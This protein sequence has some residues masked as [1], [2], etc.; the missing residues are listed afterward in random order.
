VARPVLGKYTQ[1]E[2]YRLVEQIGM[3]GMS[4]VWRA[5]D[6]VLD[7]EV[8]VKLLA[9]GAS[10]AVRERLRIEARAVAKLSHPYIAPVF[11]YGEFTAD[12]GEVTPFV[13]MELI[14][15]PSLS[16]QLRDEATPPWRDTVR[17]GAQVAAALAFAHAHGIVHR[18]VT[19]A[20]VLITSGGAKVV[21]FGIAAAVGDLELDADGMV[22]GTP[23]YL[24]PERLTGGTVGTAGDIYGL[25]LLIY[26]CLRGRLPWSASTATAMVRAHQYAEPEPLPPLAGVPAEVIDLCHACIAREPA[27][28]PSAI[29]VAYV[30]ADIV[31]LALPLA[32]PRS[33]PAWGHP[34]G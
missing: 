25:G 27:A 23:A 28:R 10:P 29:E 11:D 1:V 6:E 34:P 33:P 15:G 9:P 32:E 2:R 8:A 14:R 18:D 22:L 31:G 20:N 5:V 13:V 30:L 17:I 12:S 7:R 3:G 24:A 21:D 26:R 4:V 19:P 16:D